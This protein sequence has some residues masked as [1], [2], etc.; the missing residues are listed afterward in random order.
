M[1]DGL[2]GLA[3][4]MNG[5]GLAV[6]LA[7]G[8]RPVIG[9]GFGAPLIL[10]YLLE[11]CADVAEATETLRRLPCHMAYNF[12]LIDREG[13]HAIVMLAPDRPAIVRR[14]R[15]STNH[16]LGVEWPWHARHSNTLARS[17]RLAEVLAAREPD[18]EALQDAFL[19]PPLHVRSYAAGFG[20]IYTASYR[21]ASGSLRLLWPGLHPLEQQIDA[22]AEGVRWIGY[23]DGR[24]P[25]ELGAAGSAA[26]LDHTCRQ[27]PAQGK[28]RPS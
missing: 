28:D 1:V 12:A 6:S 10:R 5:A 3:D 22:F 20:T 9:R 7:F 27:V 19:A 16:Q 15:H 18:G 13:R 23:A 17:D 8:G 2:S 14:D 11:T 21:P 4:G 25:F 26:R 24:P